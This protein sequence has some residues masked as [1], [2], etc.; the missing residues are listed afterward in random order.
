LQSIVTDPSSTAIPLGSFTTIELPCSE[1]T[2][3]V[4]IAIEF[5]AVV[6]TEPACGT[7]AVMLFAKAGAARIGIARIGART[8]VPEIMLRNTRP[9]FMF[10]SQIDSRLDVIL[11]LLY[12]THH[13]YLRI[14]LH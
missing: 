6:R 4:E 5:G 1:R 7:E 14:C 11:S 10:S 2:A 3:A 9:A 12:N 13:A 8:I